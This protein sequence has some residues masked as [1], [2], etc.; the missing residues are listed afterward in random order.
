MVSAEITI[1]QK[2]CRS[3]IGGWTEQQ[4][5][6]NRWPS[7]KSQLLLTTSLSMLSYTT[8]FTRNSQF[9]DVP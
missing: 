4:N 3:L 6:L 7:A 8:I 1:R 2:N 5:I 9:L